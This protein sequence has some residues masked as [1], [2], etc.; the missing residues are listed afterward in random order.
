MLIKYFLLPIGVYHYG[1]GSQYY[2]T[3]T[4][5]TDSQYFC[6]WCF[7]YLFNICLKIMKCNQNIY[8]LL[9]Q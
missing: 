5:V 1:F 3:H 4:E 7:L 8:D 2:P 9:S 6:I